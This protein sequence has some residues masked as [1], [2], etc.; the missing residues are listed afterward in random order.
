[1]IADSYSELKDSIQEKSGLDFSRCKSWL[2]MM[3]FTF[4]TELFGKPYLSQVRLYFLAERA[5][6]LS[7]KPG[8]RSVQHLSLLS[9]HRK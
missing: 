2:S 9:T 7:Y 5:L 8:L 1:M 6:T 3:L 4:S